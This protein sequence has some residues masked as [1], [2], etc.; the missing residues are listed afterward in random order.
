MINNNV[1]FSN[2][3][4]LLVTHYTY[5]YKYI[6]VQYKINSCIRK[7]GKLLSPPPPN[8]NSVCAPDANRI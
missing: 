4:I 3:I 2:F 6:I 5:I 8:E 1:S 7:K